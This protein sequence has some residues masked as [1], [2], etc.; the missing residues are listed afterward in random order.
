[1][2][3]TAEQNRYVTENMG[4]VHMVVKRYIGFGTEVE[5]LV[6]IGSIGLIKAAE[7]FDK[8]KNIKFSTYAVSKIIGEIKSYIRDTG[9][10]KVSRSL[11]QNKIKVVKCRK[12]LCQRLSREPTLL[13]LSEY[14]GI[15]IDDI[16]LCSE[17]TDA[18]VSLDMESDESGSLYERVGCEDIRLDH[19]VLCD[20]IKHLSAVER[21]L[22]ILRFFRDQT[23]AKTAEQM[24]ISQVTV[25]RMEKKILKKLFD[26]LS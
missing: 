21:Q 20:A 1:M 22:V 8:E 5:D 12:M 13:E 6:Q 2:P 26:F 19:I 23:Q 16:I 25:S 9:P 7:N 4:L 11:K 15:S 17:A 3:L 18:P 10:I 24:N 14:T